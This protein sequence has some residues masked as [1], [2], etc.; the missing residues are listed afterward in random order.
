MAECDICGEEE[1]MP[2][3]C[4]HCGGTFCGDHRLPESHDCPGL[5]QWEDAGP[6]FD[7]GFNESVDPSG[8]QNSGVA[9][10]LGIDT[11]P[12]GPLAY[13]R[14]NMTFVFLGLMWVTFVTQL[15]VLGTFGDSTMESI[16]VFSPDNPLYVWTWVTS[17]FAHGGFT[18][19]AVNSIVIYFF[20]RLVEQYIGSKKFTLL[21]ILSGV[22]AGAGQVGFQIMAGAGVGV[23]GASGAALALMGVLTIMN[24]NLTV[25]LYFILPVPIWVLTGGTVVISA[26]L[27]ATG[28]PGAGGIAHVAHLVGVVIGLLY[29]QQI[30]GRVRVPRQVQFGGGRGPGGPGRGGGR[31]PF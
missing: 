11:G 17:I 22:L 18:H 23:V 21:F 19:I 24:P 30:K 26:G 31:G 2:Y 28:S 13:F 16:F 8:S 27:I 25:Y 7:S 10:R 20:G 9:D 15:V 12:G 3:E 1:S 4:R 14:G 29:G 6:V 5:E